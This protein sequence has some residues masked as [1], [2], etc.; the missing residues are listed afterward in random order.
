MERSS[1]T[2]TDAPQVAFNPL[3]WLTR[4]D[5][6]HDPAAAPP[7][8]DIYRQIH[9]AGFHAVH[10]EVPD[11]MPLTD[12]RRLLDD[13]GPGVLAICPGSEVSADGVE[14][15]RASGIMRSPNTPDPDGRPCL[16]THHHRSPPA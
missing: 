2:M 4:P 5:G 16:P 15:A 8:L 11:W 14:Q 13:Q 1:A 9:E 3:T 6:V 12:Y 10:V 7:L